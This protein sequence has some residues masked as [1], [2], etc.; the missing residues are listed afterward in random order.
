M[1]WF[2]MSRAILVHH[3]NIDKNTWHGLG[4]GCTKVGKINCI[5]RK[6]INQ[7]VSIVYLI[8]NWQLNAVKSF[9]QP[10]H[11]IS[12]ICILSKHR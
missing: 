3:T 2:L 9:I 1:F 6:K 4:P 5:V 8:V 11:S 10:V 12:A 7:S